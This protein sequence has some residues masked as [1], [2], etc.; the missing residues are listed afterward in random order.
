MR[1]DPETQPA[2]WQE[3]QDDSIRMNFILWLRAFV[4]V[5]FFG[6]QSTK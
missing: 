6:G 2:G 1:L 3:V 4:A 5:S